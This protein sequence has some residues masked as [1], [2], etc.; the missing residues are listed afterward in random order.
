MLGGCWD[1][2][3]SFESLK[4][5]Q[6]TL[7]TV[8]HHRCY[9]AKSFATRQRRAPAVDEDP[10]FVKCLRKIRK[11]GIT[12]PLY[13]DYEQVFTVSDFN[14]DSLPASVSAAGGHLPTK[15]IQRKVIQIENLIK[16]AAKFID[17]LLAART[18]TVLTPTP[19][20]T[21]SAT[22]HENEFIRV[23]E[24]CAGSGFICL[25]LAAMYPTVEFVLLDRKGKSLEIGKER[26]QAAGLSNVRVVDGDIA[27]YNEPFHVGIAL[28]ACGSASDVSLVKCIES[29][30][31]CKFICHVMYR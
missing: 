31:A 3:A 30:A 2:V 1:D 25:P 21:T 23:C 27:D 10:V 14:W 22:T 29:R 4:P 8:H 6:S 24:F 12:I 19:T 26:I 20:T 18:V 5:E 11:E 9:A 15:R 7:S 13:F 16:L 17:H 28:H